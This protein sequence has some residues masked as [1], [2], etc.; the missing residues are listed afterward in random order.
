VSPSSHPGQHTRGSPQYDSYKHT[1][2][3]SICR[4]RKNALNYQLLI[5]HSHVFLMQVCCDGILLGDECGWTANFRPASHLFTRI[6][7]PAHTLCVT[8]IYLYDTCDTKVNS[9]LLMYL[10]KNGVWQVDAMAPSAVR[11]SVLSMFDHETKMLFYS[12]AIQLIRYCYSVF[13]TA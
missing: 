10:E 9:Y 13:I 4:K 12:V 5:S 7:H 3:H 8:R 6:L 11:F 1:I 2:S